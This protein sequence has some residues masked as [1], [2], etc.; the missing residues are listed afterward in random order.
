MKSR[1][2]DRGCFEQW[3]AERGGTVGRG[4]EGE[5][6]MEGR[7]EVDVGMPNKANPY[8]GQK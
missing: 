4:W 8:A 7:K 6:E 1:L 3:L 2:T 5:D